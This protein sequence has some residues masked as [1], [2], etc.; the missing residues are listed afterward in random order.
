V[1]AKKALGLSIAFLSRFEGD[2]QHLDVVESPL[3]LLFRDGLKRDLATS[4]CQAILDG[5]LPNVI[6]NLRDFPEA[7][8]LP[9][10]KMPR[11]RS[12]VS[13]PVV[14]SDGTLYG[15]F[16]AAGLTSDR[17][18]SRRDQALMEVLARAASVI[19]E[20]GVRD[21]T[22]RAEI[23]ERL[24]PVFAAGGPNVVLQPIVD[25]ATG[26][27]VGAE[28]LSRFPADW[29]KSP[30]V[31]FAEAHRVGRGDALEILALRG[32]ARHLDHVDGYVSMNVSP[33]TLLTDDCRHLLAGLPPRRVVVELSEHD[34][35][36]DYDALRAVL[37]PLRA[38][39]LRLAIDDVGAGYSSLR[40]IVLTAPDVIKLD[41]SIVTGVG[42]DPVLRT[43]VRSLVDFARGCGSRVVAE[44]VETA[45]D[46]SALRS[47]GVD[48]G[49]GW[50]YGRPG[51]VDALENPSKDRVPIG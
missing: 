26:E 17:G 24:A 11:L 14:L 51:P 18:L 7:M 20:P 12:F 21:R 2:T 50:H 5:K 8:R 25:V 9:A 34:P 48:F 3:P 4:L 40:H 28:A 23:Q 1:T 22:E 29:A 37:A 45:E 13:V 15:T 32:A 33:G 31:V 49:Q 42:T 39:G 38:A 47:V 16:C 19:L 10:A 44:G 41:R 36:A 27:R 46:A 6:P 35:V 30:D 43:L